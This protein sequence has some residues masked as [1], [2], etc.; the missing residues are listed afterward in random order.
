M[1]LPVLGAITH[2]LNDQARQLRRRRMKQFYL[3]SVGLG[4]IFMLLQVAEI[5]QVRTVG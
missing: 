3:A 5:I 4:G 1:G 2:T